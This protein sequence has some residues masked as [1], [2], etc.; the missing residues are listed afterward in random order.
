VSWLS[1]STPLVPTG[2]MSSAYDGHG[3]R[4]ADIAAGGSNGPSLLGLDTGLAADDEVRFFLRTTPVL[5][6]RFDLDELSAVVAEGPTGV[7]TGDGDHIANGVVYAASL[8][9]TIVIGGGASGDAGLDGVGAGGG[10]SSQ[11][12]G[13]SG[14]AG[15]D[16]V[17]ATGGV[18]S[19]PSGAT[20]NAG[21]DGVD[22]TG[23]M[24]SLPSIAGGDA[25][26]EGAAAGGLVLGGG[27]GLPTRVELEAA[28][29][30]RLVRAGRTTPTRLEALDLDEVVDVWFDF[31]PVMRVPD[32]ILSVAVTCEA[33]V[34]GDP[35]APAM[36]MGAPVF[37]AEIAVQRIQPGLPGVTYLLR[38]TATLAGGGKHTAAALIKVVRKL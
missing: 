11:P 35:S 36:R 18:A 23:G 13:A 2:W 32:A 9:F 17:G 3:A 5:L 15:L 20:G 29:S 21:L 7:H 31:A 33:R 12:S 1:D 16:G 8:P 28:A 22:A 38:A 6:T 14:N 30:R 26:L 19:L 34:G 4:W 25:A 37:G 27:P 24:A 10:V